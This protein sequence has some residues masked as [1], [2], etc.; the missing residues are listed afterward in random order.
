MTQH[1]NRPGRSRD[2]VKHAAVLQAIRELLAESGY[3]KLSVDAIAKRAGVSR[4]MIYSWWNGCKP[5]LIGEAIIVDADELITP[6]SGSLEGDIKV[7]IEQSVAQYTNP[8]VLQGII[9]M[10]LDMLSDKAI[11]NAIL[12]DFTASYTAIWD[13]IIKQAQRRGE[14]SKPINTLVLM[15]TIT[16]ALQELVRTNSLENEELTPYLT[17]LA[18]SL[19]Q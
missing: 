12:E 14:I 18:V 4:P 5:I 8:G 3:T 19:C 16:G 7:L 17:Q 11:T 13:Q 2:P 1:R 15:H 10:S 6:D 9:G